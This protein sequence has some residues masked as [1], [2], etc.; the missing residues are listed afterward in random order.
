MARLVYLGSP[1]VAVGPLRALV[2]AG[3][4]ILL[5]VSQPDKRRGR[6]GALSPSPVKAAA[7]DLG[8][9]VSDRVD[10][11]LATGADLGVVVAFGR[12]IK[13]HVLAVV[14]M[15]NLHFSVLPRWRGAAPV[16][17]AL[18]SGDQSTGVCLMALEE[19][20]DTGPVYECRE[21]PIT[22]EDTLDA[23]R[24]R[25]AELGTEILVRRLSG[26]AAT[27]GEPRAQVG[28]GT[29]APK[30]TPEHLRLDWTR[31][32]QELERVVRLGGAWTTMG[33][34]RLRVLAADV[35]DDGHDAPR[36]VPGTI[37]GVRVGTGQGSLRL[38]LV[39]P[40]GKGSMDAGAWL[41]GARLPAGTTLGS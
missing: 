2:D 11:V 22:A 21:T 5:V 13:P 12:L 34:R 38:S 25:L 31:P 18:L 4:E 14:P 23:L 33:G 36:L 3:H 15:V 32:A 30:L 10:D 28:D 40:E 29:Y 41:R 1:E 8:L 26:G 20:L 17:W 6:G 35:D 27:L 19:G 37:D 24:G 39:Q 7:L 9:P 16:E